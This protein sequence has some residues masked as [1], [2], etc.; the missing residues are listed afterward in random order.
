MPERKIRTQAM[1]GSELLK[2]EFDYISRTAYQADEDRARVSSFYLLAVGSMIA[3]L[4][5]TQFFDE[6][7]DPVLVALA[8]S[9]LFFI[10]TI[11]GTLTTLQLSRLRAA[12]YDSMVAMNQLKDYWLH[13]AKEKNINK[14]FKWDAATL[15]GK[16]KL[17]SV[18]FY[19]TVEVALLSGVTFG[20]SVYFFQKGI[21]FACPS[22][23]NWTITCFLG[24]LASLF[25]LW[26]Y[27]LNLGK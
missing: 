10:L 11:L 24:F 14:A 21:G 2:S 13:E 4:L 3:A 16:F 1:S 17:N 26:I 18:S 25:Q 12:W 19:Q 22:S 23:C 6:N 5:S 15:P 8:F 7:L 20:A 27:K 9:G